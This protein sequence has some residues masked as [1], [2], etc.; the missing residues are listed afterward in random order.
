MHI[1]VNL[2]ACNMDALES[3]SCMEL[4]QICVFMFVTIIVQWK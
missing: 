4:S 1:V 2:Q 3:K